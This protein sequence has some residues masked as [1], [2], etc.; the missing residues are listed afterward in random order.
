MIRRITKFF[1][2]MTLMFFAISSVS[3]AQNII[4][5]LGT[6]KIVVNGFDW[7]PAVDRV[8]VKIGRAHV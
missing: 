5:S 1:S 6:Y 4:N 8:I 7:G 2:L 3:F